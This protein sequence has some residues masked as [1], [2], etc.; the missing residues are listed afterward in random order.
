MNR[1]QNRE[2]LHCSEAD[3]DK[4]KT[5]ALEKGDTKDDQALSPIEDNYIQPMCMNS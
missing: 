1:M 2:V 3:V 4:P 5:K